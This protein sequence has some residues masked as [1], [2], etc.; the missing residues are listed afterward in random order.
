MVLLAGAADL[1][2]LLR[3]SAGFLLAGALPF[4]SRVLLPNLGTVKY[5]RRGAEVGDS[6][7]RNGAVALFVMVC[8]FLGGGLI[9]F[10]WAPGAGWRAWMS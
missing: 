5:W 2:F 4:S 9:L 8:S 3:F 6:S 1:G 7:V 10:G